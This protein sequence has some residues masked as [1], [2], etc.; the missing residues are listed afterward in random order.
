M[1]ILNRPIGEITG[2]VGRYIGARTAIGAGAGAAYGMYKG[3]GSTLR[4]AAA[5]AIAGSAF[6]V[7]IPQAF[8]R[9]A[10]MAGVRGGLGNARLAALR[11]LGMRGPF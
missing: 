7:G 11:P 3:D 5:G 1:S 4:S 6:H 10:R 2:L 8:W 9:G